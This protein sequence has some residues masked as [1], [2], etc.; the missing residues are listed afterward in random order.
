MDSTTFRCRIDARYLIPRSSVQLQARNWSTLEFYRKYQD[1][2]TPAGLAFF[3]SDWD[4]SVKEFYHSTLG[5]HSFYLDSCRRTLMR[6]S[7]N[8]VRRCKGASVSIR[9]SKT[10]S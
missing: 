3:Q 9:L 7:Y 10:A 1:N 5:I 8:F 2:L 4:S 6:I